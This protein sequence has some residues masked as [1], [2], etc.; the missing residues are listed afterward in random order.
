MKLKNI[1]SEYRCPKCDR[2]K[3]N[4]ELTEY[5]FPEQIHYRITMQCVACK[6]YVGK[7]DL[8]E[9]KDVE[10]KSRPRKNVASGF[11]S[12]GDPAQS[13]D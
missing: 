2:I 5:D 1:V 8:F 11:G 10:K 12:L 3:G 9:K 7:V 13:T 4:H 6:T